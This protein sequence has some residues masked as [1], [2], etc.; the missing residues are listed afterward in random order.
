[1]GV[2]QSDLRST[3]NSNRYSINEDL[4]PD[5]YPRAKTM[6]SQT[7][8]KLPLQPIAQTR[9]IA[10]P[11]EEIADVSPWKESSKNNNNSS[12]QNKID[13]HKLNVQVG[14]FSINGA[15]IHD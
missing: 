12:Y 8:T 2:F 4:P 14:V 9:V 13:T 6:M 10:L 5:H 15:G 11:M 1:M 3:L 7:L